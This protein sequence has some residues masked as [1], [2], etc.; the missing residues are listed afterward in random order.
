MGVFD[1]G[2]LHHTPTLAENVTKFRICL[3]VGFCSGSSSVCA[4]VKH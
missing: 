4:E 3:A 1:A 2:T